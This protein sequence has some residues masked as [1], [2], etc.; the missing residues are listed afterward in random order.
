MV[1]LRW[2]STSNEEECRCENAKN[3]SEEKGL[4]IPDK[5]MEDF[6]FKKKIK[7][8]KDSHSHKLL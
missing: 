5:P 4:P 6:V 2:A 1:N 3:G 7:R 8:Q